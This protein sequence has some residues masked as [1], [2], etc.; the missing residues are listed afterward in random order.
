MTF[1]LTYL[2]R[3]EKSLKRLGDADDDDDDIALNVSF[4]GDQSAP[5]NLD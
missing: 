3:R 5:V 1:Q 2:Y 4:N